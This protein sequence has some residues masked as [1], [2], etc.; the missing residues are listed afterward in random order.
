MSKLAGRL[1]PSEREEKVN[2]SPCL[3][4]WY[5]TV[6]EWRPHRGMSGDTVARR[7]TADIDSELAV[8]L[9]LRDHQYLL[10]VRS[11]ISFGSEIT[12]IF[13]F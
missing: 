12:N 8:R 6:E 1:A 5:T 9:L 4:E 7:M 2:K 11:P 10:V 3:P 13:W